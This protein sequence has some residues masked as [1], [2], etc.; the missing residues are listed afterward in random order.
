MFSSLFSSGAFKK[1]AELTNTSGEELKQAIY[2]K[3]DRILVSCINCWGELN[4]F[5]NKEYF[6]MRSGI[7]PYTNNDEADIAKKIYETNDFTEYVN[8]K[9]NLI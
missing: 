1:V 9:V 5:L 3:L 4:I 7:L 2:A 6:L 8:S